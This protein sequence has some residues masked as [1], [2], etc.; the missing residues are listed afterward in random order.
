MNEVLCRKVQ[1]CARKCDHCNVVP[2]LVPEIR[3]CAYPYQRRDEKPR[4][5]QPHSAVIGP[6]VRKVDLRGQG[7]WREEAEDGGVGAKEYT[8]RIMKC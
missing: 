6:L 4:A 5:M 3:E 2:V 7:I 1:R 8:L